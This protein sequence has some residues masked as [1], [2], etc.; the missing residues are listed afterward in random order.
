MVLNKFLTPTVLAKVGKK[1]L[2][3]L[4]I[5]INN[6]DRDSLNEYGKMIAIDVQIL[7]DKKKTIN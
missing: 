1:I 2:N 3:H 4:P 5:M 6:G 7:Q